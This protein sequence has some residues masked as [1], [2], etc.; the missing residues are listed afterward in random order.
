MNGRG[1][2][3]VSAGAL[4]ACIASVVGCQ[5]LVGL[6]GAELAEPDAG[7]DAGHDAGRDAGHAAGHDAGLDAGHD[8][9]LD[10]G[11]DGGEGGAAPGSLGEPCEADGGCADQ[12][13]CVTQDDV[14]CATLCGLKCEACS[15]VKTGQASGTCAPIL[16]GEDPDN[17]CGDAGG[18]GVNNECRCQDG[19]KDGDETDIDCG[20]T[21]CAPCEGGKT[22][23]ADSDCAPEVP[24]CVS[25]ACCVGTC[26]N[27]PCTACGPTGQC[28][29]VPPGASDP[30]MYCPSGTACGS[31]TLGCVGKAGAVCN[32]ATG[33]ADCLSGSCPVATK[34]CSR[35]GVGKPCNTNADCTSGNCQS[36]VCM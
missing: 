35:G 22:C 17:E 14:C 32:P 4:A 18:C 13:V 31:A 24:A 12:T 20:G 8:A 34:T 29:K 36:Y 3:T 1:R 23:N 19:V 10:A 25:G 28:V 11:S 9:G 5:L 33:G 30:N 27:G 2:V 6:H 26:E 21:T 16:L 7:T 15:K